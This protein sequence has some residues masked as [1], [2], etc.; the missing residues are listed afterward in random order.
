MANYDGHYDNDLAKAQTEFD[1]RIAPYI[2]E[3]IETVDRFDLKYQG[4]LPSIRESIRNGEISIRCFGEIDGGAGAVAARREYRA[5]EAYARKQADNTREYLSTLL[6]LTKKV[7]DEKISA[8]VEI[9]KHEIPWYNL[10]VQLD[11]GEL[12]AALRKTAK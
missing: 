6:S 9:E 10:Y 3:W 4:K 2:R 5:K 7:Q 8:G 1:S 11:K 12:E